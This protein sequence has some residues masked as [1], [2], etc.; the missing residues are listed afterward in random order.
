MNDVNFF[1]RNDDDDG[2]GGLQWWSVA[3]ERV[4]LPAYR[5]LK[6]PR[7]K[8]FP[9]LSMSLLSTDLEAGQEIDLRTFVA[10]KLLRGLLEVNLPTVSPLDFTTE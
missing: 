6:M 8:I 2:A 10:R 4:C 5:T 7:H 9:F 1:T 3:F